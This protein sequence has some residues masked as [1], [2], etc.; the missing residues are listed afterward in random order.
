MAGKTSGKTTPPPIDGQRAHPDRER[1]DQ[2]L[3]AAAEHFRT[4]GYGKTTISDIARGIGISHAYIYRFFES[5]Q[6]IGE[7]VCDYTL[8]RIGHAV[9]EVVGSAESACTRL[10]KIPEVLVE[11]GLAVFFRDRKLHDLTEAAVREGWCSAS[12]HVQ[13]IEQAIASL[14]SDGRES[15][16][17]ERKTP[18]DE[19]A[20]S[21]CIA[22]TPF[23][24]PVLLAQQ[25][26]DDLRKHARLVS[27]MILR[28][29]AP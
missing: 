27:S 6:A 18:Q 15:G 12:N 5:K 13:S 26:P 14:V 28:S 11:E 23:I 29:L 4:F 16:E 21:I 17:F 24:H 9:W 3:A 19:V 20:R 7:A 2:I 22:F 8:K 25:E 10:R 1:R